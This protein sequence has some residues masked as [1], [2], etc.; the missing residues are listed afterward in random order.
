M[1]AQQL[2]LKAHQTGV[3]IR[4]NNGDLQLAPARLLTPAR[5]R[6]V[7]T[8]KPQLVAI[9]TSLEQQG[10]VNDPLILEALVLFNVSITPARMSLEAPRMPV[11]EPSDAIYSPR[12]GRQLVLL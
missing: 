6:A 10:C 12:P 5:I 3:T 1:T 9:V 11:N 7:K 4:V 8:L 2:L